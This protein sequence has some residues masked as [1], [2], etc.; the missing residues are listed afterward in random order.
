MNNDNFSD[1]LFA[2]NGHM[3]TV[4]GELFRVE[5][6][7]AL[8][9]ARE[10]GT[11]VVGLIPFDPQKKPLLM[12]PRDW[13]TVSLH[14]AESCTDMPQPTS[15]SGLDN[16]AYRE[17]VAVALERLNRGELDKVVLAR[18][19]EVSYEN[20]AINPADL[21]RNLLV[22]Q[23]RAFVFSAKL[24]ESQNYLMGASPELVLR[25]VDGQFVTHPLAGS[26][27]RIRPLG[28]TE[29]VQVGEGLMHSTKDRAEHATVVDDIR[30][31][32]EPFTQELEVP[33]VPSLLATPQLWHL[34]TRIIGKLLADVTSLD[35]ARAIHPTPA[36]CG[37]P[38]SPALKLIQELENFDRGYF[39]GLVGWMDTEGNGEW[40]LTLRCAEVSRNHAKLFAGAGIIKGS[41]PASEHQETAHKLGSFGQA[42]NILTFPI[43]QV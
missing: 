37:F 28:S 10:H 21:Y 36:I 31:R 35:G 3:L 23:P 22:Q 41:T 12:V 16:P 8:T 4:S 11:G 14:A 27:P 20:A 18:L 29:D 26:S 43:N 5:E 9:L 39:G 15:I 38:T 6:S 1:F 32:F 30:T 42:L 19:L 13:K 2:R 33:S 40:A 34:G 24:P 25:S 17:A 7:N